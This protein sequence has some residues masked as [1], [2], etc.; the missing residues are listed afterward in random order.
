MI[1]KRSWGEVTMGFWKEQFLLVIPTQCKVI[2]LWI[3]PWSG[4]VTVGRMTPEADAN[5]H[6]WT[7]VISSSFLFA[8][9]SSES[10]VQTNN[11]CAAYTVFGMQ[12]SGHACLQLRLPCQGRGIMT[13][14]RNGV[15]RSKE[16]EWEPRA[17]GRRELIRIF[18]IIKKEKVWGD[19]RTEEEGKH[20]LAPRSS[21][22]TASHL[23]SI[24]VRLYIL[25]QIWNPL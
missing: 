21:G 16:S 20:I 4:W 14:S 6:V 3:L 25:W 1:Q 19:G 17:C 7:L 22:P 13:P 2:G 9:L 12:K 5:A 8:I 10:S 11:C 24:G 18:I 23:G 15:V